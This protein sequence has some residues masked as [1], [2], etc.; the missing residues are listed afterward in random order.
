MRKRKRTDYLDKLRKEQTRVDASSEDVAKIN[1]LLNDISRYLKN[2]KSFESNQE[3]LGMRNMF[4][5]IVVK[6]W[7]GNNFETSA[8]CKHNKMIVK[9]SA[10][11]YNEHWVDR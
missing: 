3:M 4:R 2:E 10:R 11:F 9:E 5:G 1:S 8:D 6:S 7:T